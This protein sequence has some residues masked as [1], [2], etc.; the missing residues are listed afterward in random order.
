MTFLHTLDLSL[1]VVVVSGDSY[2]GFGLGNKE[3]RRC[4]R[5]NQEKIRKNDVGI[6][7]RSSTRK[8][9]KNWLRN[10]CSE[11]NFCFD[12]LVIFLLAQAQQIAIEVFVVFRQQRVSLGWA[13]RCLGE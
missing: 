3:C 7:D 4:K 2:E 1:L 11:N 8:K 6:S 5:K 10:G 13:G 9:K 12:E